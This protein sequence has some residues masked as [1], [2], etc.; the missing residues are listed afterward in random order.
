MGIWF[1]GSALGNLIAGLIA[2]QIETLPLQ[3]L[4]GSVAVIAI[5]AGILFLIFTPIIKKLTGGI[6]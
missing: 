1:M 5:A 4:F 2:G 3:E 6:N